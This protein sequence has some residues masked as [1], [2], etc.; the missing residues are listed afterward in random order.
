[1]L[2]AI[3]FKISF[4]QWLL[5]V[6]ALFFIVDRVK[7][8]FKKE[9]KQTFLKFIFSLI[10]WG[11]VLFFSLFP[12]VARQLSMKLGLGE[13]LNVLIFFGFVI[14]FIII[15]KIL[16]IVERNERNITEIVRKNALRDLEKYKKKKK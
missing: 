7:K 6:V 12:D 9:Y 13:N 5:I 1:M 11:G 2:K 10:I 14:V 8:F 16:E 15:F 4:F 3:L